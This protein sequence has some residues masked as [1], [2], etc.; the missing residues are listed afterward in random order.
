M[1]P[2]NVNHIPEVMAPGDSSSPPPPDAT[3]AADLL[4]QAFSELTELKLALAASQQQL[5]SA[6]R[7][8]EALTETNACLREELTR[9]SLHIV[10][11]ACQAAMCAAEADVNS[12]P[13]QQFTR[14]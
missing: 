5:K 9:L 7:Q 13:F 2:R 10:D 8:I 4:P 14:H 1:K 3:P 12:A 6:R 11:E